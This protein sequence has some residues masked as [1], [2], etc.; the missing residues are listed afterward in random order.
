VDEVAGKI[1]GE[2]GG[3]VESVEGGKWMELGEVG[4]WEEKDEGDCGL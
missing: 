3:V 2:V 4:A 1:W